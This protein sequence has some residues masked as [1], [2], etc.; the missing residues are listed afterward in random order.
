MIKPSVTMEV[1]ISGSWVDISADVQRPI[2][3]ELGIGGTPSPINR[4]ANVGRLSFALD[5]SNRN[6]ASTL[7][8]YSPDH[9]SAL[10]GWEENIELRCY[11]YHA[12]YS[13]GTPFAQF[14]GWIGT[15]RPTPRSTGLRTVNVTAV[16]LMQIL[17]DFDDVPLLSLITDSPSPA[18]YQA[19]IDALNQKPNGVAITKEGLYFNGSTTAILVANDTAIQDLHSGDF[20]V[21]G[22]FQPDSAGESGTG[23]FFGKGSSS[24]GGWHVRF[25]GVSTTITLQAD[26]STTDIQESKTGLSALDDGNPHRITVTFTNSDK[27]MRLFIDGVLVHTTSAGSGS[28]NT[29]SANSLGIGCRFNGSQSFEGNIYWVHIATAVLFTEDFDPLD[30]WFVPEITSDTVGLWRL[31]EAT[32]SEAIDVVNG[33]N[34]TITDGTWL[35]YTDKLDILPYIFHR[36]GERSGSGYEEMNRIALS[37]FDY[38]YTDRNGYLVAQHREE[39]VQET[40][41]QFTIQSDLVDLDYIR[42]RSRGYDK[43]TAITHPVKVGV[44]EETAFALEA[45]IRINP[46]DS[47]TLIAKYTEPSSTRPCGLINPVA[48]ATGTNVQFGSLDNGTAGD[49]N[50]DLSITDNFYSAAAEI[51]FTNNGDRLGFLNEVTITG[52][53]LRFYNPVETTK[54]INANG[55]RFFRYDLPLQDSEIFA[56]NANEMIANIYN[57][58]SGLGVRV[59]FRGNT[60]TT[61]G[62]FIAGDLGKRMKITE[63]VTGASNFEGYINKLKWDLT[64][65]GELMVEYLVSPASTT[66]NGIWGTS[67]WNQAVW[68]FAEG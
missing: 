7:G 47:Y 24:N 9:G 63:T 55:T 57:Q 52:Y 68:Q 29:D 30:Y 28:A 46:G 33:N 54:V 61:F 19:I 14:H 21:D 11:M 56:E 23:Y 42:D 38:V 20:T 17:N 67:K 8:Y 32:G 39:R 13:S 48:L 44:A 65:D 58:S 36:S 31:N 25:G 4:I 62:Y 64:K 66:T 59:K 26:F 18:G 27:K 34:G 12:D 6:S 45:P 22:Y 40:T 49:L 3:C 53:L 35:G 50:N 15:I 41:V 60:L 5:N 10:S 37:V 43:I 1:K 51:V 16:D 2:S